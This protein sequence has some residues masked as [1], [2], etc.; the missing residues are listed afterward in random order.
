MVGTN[1]PKLFLNILTMDFNVT[2]EKIN[3]WLDAP[4][5]F[6][7]HNTAM[8]E[9]QPGTGEWFL[10]SKEFADWKI[11]ANS[12]IWLHG[13]RES[14]KPFQV[15][16]LLIGLDSWMWENSLMVSSFTINYR[17]AGVSPWKF[18]F[19]ENT[20]ATN[21]FDRICSSTIIHE[22]IS[23]H[24]LEPEIA[25]AYFYFNFS[26]LDKKRTEKLIRSLIVQLLAQCQNLPESLESA[27]SHSQNGQNQPTIK[28]LTKLL[29]QMVKMFKSTYILL[30][31]LDECTDRKDLL[32]LIEEIIDWNMDSLH[33][34]GTSRKE[35][36][37][38]KSLEPL[39]PSQL[40]IQSKLVDPD[41]RIHVL[42]KLSNDPLL[43]KWPANVQKEI[44]NALTRG[45]NGM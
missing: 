10:Q 30:D 40:C 4:L 23:N 20:Q 41:I 12:F 28:E 25:V 37:I 1:S 8:L 24:Q 26:D 14:Y 5:P 33:L 7:N 19:Y 6:L 43:R 21:K 35:S 39:N 45:A 15:T 31:A 38:T 32:E 29:H 16:Q 36:D 13:I 44:E 42:K 17:F 3:Q 22:V 9:K 2:V 27:Y 11:G 34:L 18:R